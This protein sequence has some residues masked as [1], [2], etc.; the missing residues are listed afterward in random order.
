MNEHRTTLVTLLSSVCLLVSS[1]SH[2]QSPSA[3]PN[4]QLTWPDVTG[5][6]SRAE[7]ERAILHHLGEATA[8]TT[9]IL[10]SVTIE[11]ADGYR[12][13]LWMRNKSTQSIRAL[14]GE[15]CR[16]VTDAA[17]VILA[18]LLADDGLA[19]MP[20][21][22]APVAARPLTA[23]SGALPPTPSRVA[24]SLREFRLRDT[25]IARENSTRIGLGAWLPLG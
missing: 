2:A 18:M 4:L 24:P 17:V 13:I 10:A 5:C 16:H 21:D 7:V 1:A 3:V 20:L 8:H 25:R 22:A 6:P 11:P 19:E 14:H 9:P 15:D 23:P 12:L